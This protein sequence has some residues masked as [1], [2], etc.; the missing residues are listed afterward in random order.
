MKS[1]KVLFT[2]KEAANYLGYPENTLRVSR[3]SG[4]LSGHPAPL[5]IKIG[6]KTI[7]YKRDELDKWI[8]GLVENNNQ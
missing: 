2:S 4:F 3:M 5:H 1:I 6:K 8:N 7:R